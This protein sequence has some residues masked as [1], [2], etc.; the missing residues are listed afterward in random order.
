MFLFTFVRCRL[1]LHR[2]VYLHQIAMVF[3]TLEK[4]FTYIFEVKYFTLSSNTIVYNEYEIYIQNIKL[5]YH[6]G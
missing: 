1:C 3:I 6:E 2:Y 5:Y 4:H